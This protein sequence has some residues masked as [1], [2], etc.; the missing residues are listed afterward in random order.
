MNSVNTAARVL[1][2]DDEPDIRELLEITLA[3]MGLET[4]AAADLAEARAC[5]ERE[6]LQLCLTDMRL[7]DGNGIALVEHIQARYPELPV[8]M[9]TAHGNVDS[10]I[11]ALKAGAFDFISKPVG[12]EKLRSLVTA[13][14]ELGGLSGAESAAQEELIGDTPA[15]REL[16]AQIDKVARSQAPVHV[17]G[18][19]G[20]GKEL[21][22]R[23]IHGR[24]PRATG[25]FV[26]VNCGAI[27]DELIESE[28]FG[29]IKGAFTGASRD[30]LGLF[31]A[32]EGG[33]LFLDEVAELPMAMQVKLLRVIQ[34]KRVRPVGANEELAAD[35]RLLSATHKDL[36]QEVA[37]GRFREDLYFRINVI[38]LQVPSLR[39]RRADIPMLADAILKRI[40]AANGTGVASLSPD[41]VEAL[42]D[43]SFPGNVRELENI[44]E[45]ACALSDGLR[46]D[47]SDLQI[48]APPRAPR[49]REAGT[50]LLTE[51]SGDLDAYLADIERNVLTEALEAHRWNRTEAA[52][53][54]GIGFRSL[55]YR[56]KKLGIDD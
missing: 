26:P 38:D 19:S 18:E 49:M 4:V 10:A 48:N 6:S 39:E 43:Y 40:A 56:L 14:L 37:L 20:T 29:H 9:I 50:S 51:V 17:R 27:P 54:L 31:Q 42:S 35:V 55:R 34:E 15:M 3:R 46:I 23:R 30:K 7:P 28:L 13:A 12:L 16:R 8:A 24:G 45:R 41:A 52:Q 36:S 33:T 47:R 11:R 25:P 53:S 22:A 32:A 21:V 5:L 44:L 2:V 1:V